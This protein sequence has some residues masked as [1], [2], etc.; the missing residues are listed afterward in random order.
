MPDIIR[1]QVTVGHECPTCGSIR[2][3]KRHTKISAAAMATVGVLFIGFA[4]KMW[5]VRL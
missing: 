4:V 1:T 5:T 2:A 3:F